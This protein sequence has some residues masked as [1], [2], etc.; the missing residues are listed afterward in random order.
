MTYSMSCS[1]SLW[2]RA[3]VRADGLCSGH[4]LLLVP[5][6]LTPTLSREREREQEKGAQR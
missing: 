1:L 4:A 5:L 2:E 6:A 3:G